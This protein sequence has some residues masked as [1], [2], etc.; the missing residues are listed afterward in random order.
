MER[1]IN[2]K[3][4]EEVMDDA[5]IAKWDLER[6]L[7]KKNGTQGRRLTFRVGYSK[8]KHRL[9]KNCASESN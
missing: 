1:V 4:S 3:R 6:R 5:R 8:I 2:F 7:I 9:I